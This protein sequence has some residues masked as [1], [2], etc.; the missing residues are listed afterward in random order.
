MAQKYN[1][2]IAKIWLRYCLEK[3]TLP[4]QKY[5][6]KERIKENI[7]IDFKIDKEDMDYLDSLNHILSTRYLR[8]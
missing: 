8:D 3:N 2:T 6:H 7:D 1:T 5:V 4:L